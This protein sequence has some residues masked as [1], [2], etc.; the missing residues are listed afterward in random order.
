PPAAVTAS[1]AFTAADRALDRR[2]AQAD[3]HYAS[4]IVGEE[5]AATLITLRQ[6]Q[7]AR[8]AFRQ[9]RQPQNNTNT[10]PIRI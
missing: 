8:P 6:R 1:P 10:K 2:A 5:A 4:R 7:P 9:A 3:T